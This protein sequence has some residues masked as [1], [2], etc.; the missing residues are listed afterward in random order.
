[1]KHVE[2][3]QLSDLSNVQIMELLFKKITLFG[4][5]VRRVPILFS[6]F[7]SWIEENKMDFNQIAITIL[8]LR[9]EVSAYLSLVDS[10]SESRQTIIILF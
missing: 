6:T 9:Q 3:R 8:K 1:M 7:Y 2:Y 4:C 10:T 5:S